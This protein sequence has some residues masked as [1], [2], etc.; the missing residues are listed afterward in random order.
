[1]SLSVENNHCTKFRETSSRAWT[2]NDRKGWKKRTSVWSVEYVS[3]VE[4]NKGIRACD[5][6]GI[7]HRHFYLEGDQSCDSD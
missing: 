1:M 4:F 5:R 3:Y 2:H 7:C 6:I